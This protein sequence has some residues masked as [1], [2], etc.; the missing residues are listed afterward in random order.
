MT[1]ERL[2]EIAKQLEALEAEIK[3]S[4]FDNVPDCSAKHELVQHVK[5]SE[6]WARCLLSYVKFHNK[7][8]S[9]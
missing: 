1:E 6:C 5:E 2:S 7:R 8:A 3:N 9:S 4:V